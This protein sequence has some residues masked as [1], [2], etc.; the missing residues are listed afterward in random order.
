L[1]NVLVLRY[2]EEN[3]MITRE[4]IIAQIRAAKRSFKRWPK[5][6]REAAYFATTGPVETP[7]RTRRAR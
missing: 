5:W 3:A 6:M 1:A 2:E 7:R 4:Q